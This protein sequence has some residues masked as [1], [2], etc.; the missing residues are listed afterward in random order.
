MNYK[1]IANEIGV[2][3]SS[4]H[5]QYLSLGRPTKK[6]GL[7]FLDWESNKTFAFEKTQEKKGGN[8]LVLSAPY[9]DSKD[10]IEAKLKHGPHGKQVDSINIRSSNDKAKKSKQFIEISYY[11]PTEQMLEDKKIIAYMNNKSKIKTAGD[12]VRGILRENIEPMA[13]Q[14]M[15]HFV[16]V[17]RGL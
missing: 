12:A 5:D 8:L 6:G 10:K 16:E 1:L 7:R 9:T 14:C 15:D 11:I 3:L 4:V 17:M 2:I 13:K